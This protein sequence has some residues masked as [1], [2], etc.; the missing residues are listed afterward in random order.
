[1]AGRR[2]LARRRAAYVRV[3]GASRTGACVAS[4]WPPPASGIV[5][6][7]DPEPPA[8]RPGARRLMPGRPGRPAGRRRPRGRA[9]RARGQDERRRQRPGPGDPDRATLPDLPPVAA[10]PVP[11]LALRTGEAIGVVGPLVQAG[12]FGVPELRGPSEDRG[13][14]AA[15]EDPGPG[16]LHPAPAAGLRHRARRTTA[17]LAAAQ[18]LAFLDRP[19]T[20]PVT[21][22]GTLELVL[23]ECS[24]AATWRPHP[25]CGCGAGP[26]PGER[27]DRP[28][29]PVVLPWPDGS[30]AA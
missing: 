20:V 1:M 19:E 12:P 9:C 11:D 7:A 15:A 10:R 23:P 18:V 5:S 26:A 16:H 6:C 13:R 17:T 22:D 21:A 28:G 30:L 14:P 29:Q 2:T 3:H 4:S 27:R 8:R 25:A 24:C